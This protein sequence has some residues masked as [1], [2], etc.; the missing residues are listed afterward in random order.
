MSVMSGAACNICCFFSDKTMPLK[1]CLRKSTVGYILSGILSVL[2]AVLLINHLSRVL[3]RSV[4]STDAL[5]S[6]T[7]DIL[8]ELT[9]FLNLEKLLPSY[10]FTVTVRLLTCFLS[11]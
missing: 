9:R 1:L 7:K 5:T 3:C 10:R 6:D 4:P 11:D 2:S 8:E